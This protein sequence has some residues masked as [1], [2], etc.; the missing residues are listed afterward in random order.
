MRVRGQGYVP[1][2]PARGALCGLAPRCL[3]PVSKPTVTAGAPGRAHRPAAAARR[4]PQL[5]PHPV[6]QRVLQGGGPAGPHPRAGR[7]RGAVHH[8]GCGPR[9]RLPHAV[10]V[11]HPAARHNTGHVPRAHRPVVMQRRARARGRAHMPSCAAR[12]ILYSF[13]PPPPRPP[14]PDVPCECTAV[15][16]T[17]ACPALCRPLPPFPFRPPAASPPTGAQLAGCSLRATTPTACKELE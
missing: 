3:L 1:A 17:Q 12:T 13:F 8:A 4:A 6:P 10:P 5:P 11:R 14:P 15:A 7:W 2:H 9:G 16:T